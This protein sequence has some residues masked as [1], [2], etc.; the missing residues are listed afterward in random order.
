MV[1]KTA[2]TTG[3]TGSSFL[4]ENENQ[5]SSSLAI[6]SWDCSPLIWNIRDGLSALE[7]EDRLSLDALKDAE[8]PV[9]GDQF[10][11]EVPSGALFIKTDEIPTEGSKKFVDSGQLWEYEQENPRGGA[12]MEL[13]PGYFVGFVGAVVPASKSIVNIVV[14]GNITIISSSTGNNFRVMLSNDG[15]NFYETR[16]ESSSLSVYGLCI[17]QK[18]TLIACSRAASGNTIMRSTDLG[19]TWAVASVPGTTSISAVTEF[20]GV[21]VASC[22]QGTGNRALYSYDDGVSW[23]F[24]STH[25]DNVFED[26]I[27]HK[28]KFY[29]V[30][31]EG[32]QRLGVSSDWGQ[33]FSGISVSYNKYYTRLATFKDKLILI[34]SAPS[35]APRCVF[36]EDE[37]VTFVEFFPEAT[38]SFQLFCGIQIGDYFFVGGTDGYLARSLDLVTWEEIDNPLSNNIFS[39]SYNY[40]NGKP[41]IYAATAD[42]ST[43]TRVITSVH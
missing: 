2:S 39:I 3:K 9:N 34:S 22:R 31:P 12:S 6:Q 16:S 8:Q 24:S 37:G 13:V 29:I 23:F 4:S 25:Q 41:V 5:K 10:G 14:Y 38:S 26:I 27:Y 35:T 32:T 1:K 28:G 15:K 17:N 30:S 7:G 21:W 42:L 20:G 36:T 18:G 19:N 43:G 11:L 40:V 33:T